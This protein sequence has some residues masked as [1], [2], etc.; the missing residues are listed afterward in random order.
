VWVG[1][2]G[3]AVFFL[4]GEYLLG[5]YLG[6]Q[7]TASAYGAAGSVVLILMWIYYSSLILFAGAEFTQVYAR[8]TGR[9]IQPGKHAVRVNGPKPA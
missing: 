6:R 4:A 3:T 1:A 7:S 5:L 8:Q 9:P 2:F